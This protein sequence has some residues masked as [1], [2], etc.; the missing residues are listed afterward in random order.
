MKG[1][2]VMALTDTNLNKFDKRLPNINP[3]YLPDFGSD[4]IAI[5]SAVSIKAACQALNSLTTNT[6]R[7]ITLESEIDISGVE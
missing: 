2:A 5:S 6:I 7:S 4:T 3:A 1:N